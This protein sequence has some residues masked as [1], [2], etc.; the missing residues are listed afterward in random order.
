MRQ[1]CFDTCEPYHATAVAVTPRELEITAGEDV[2]S[3]AAL[4][5]VSSKDVAAGMAVDESPVAAAVGMV[6]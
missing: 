6:S 3:V 1:I 2:R 4:V 5:M